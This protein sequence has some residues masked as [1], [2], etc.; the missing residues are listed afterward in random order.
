MP[1]NCPLTPSKHEF[2]MAVLHDPGKIIEIPNPFLY[3]RA[4]RKKFSFQYAEADRQPPATSRQPSVCAVKGV[5][6]LCFGTF[7]CFFTH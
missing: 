4:A 1:E 5:P 2:E 7:S 3:S 6:Q